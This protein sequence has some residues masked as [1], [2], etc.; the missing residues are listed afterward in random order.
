MVQ[1]WSPEPCDE[2]DSVDSIPPSIEVF[3]SDGSED[4]GNQ[5]FGYVQLP[6]DPSDFNSNTGA[7]QDT[8]EEDG[9]TEFP[10]A[11]SIAPELS[12]LAADSEIITDE[13]A[14]RQD[15]NINCDVVKEVMSSVTLPPSAFPPWA[16]EIPESQ[17]TSFILERIN[18][19]QD[20][21]QSEE[22][23][24]THTELS[25]SPT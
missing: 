12:N 16:L 20:S 7:L 10:N 4:D 8:I 9:W 21:N 23:V 2:G 17:W 1:E 19:Q 6:L 25:Q 5:H 3:E 18:S 22:K 11:T 15:I 14:E 13:P 24:Q